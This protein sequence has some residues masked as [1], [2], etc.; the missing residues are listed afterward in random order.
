M[1]ERRKK[2]EFEA[3]W[4]L[5]R[6]GN[7]IL[8]KEV[9]TLWSA[10]HFTGC[11]RVFWSER[12]CSA[13]DWI[14]TLRSGKDRYDFR[15]RRTISKEDAEKMGI[16]MKDA[17]EVTLESEYEKIAQIDTSN[18]ENVRGP[19]PWEEGNKLYEE[20]VERVKKMETGK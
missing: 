5:V 19:R 4:Q 18:W 20:A 11:W 8:W 12:V 17:Q 14:Q 3:V 9:H 6:H 1:M 10:I 15:T 16:K 13:Q 2:P 7:P